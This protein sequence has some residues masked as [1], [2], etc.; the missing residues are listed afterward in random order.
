MPN[1]RNRFNLELPKPTSENGVE[2][3]F[4]CVCLHKE[5]TELL[6][7]NFEIAREQFSIG[8][9]KYFTKVMAVLYLKR[10]CGCYYFK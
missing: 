10:I 3:L 2:Y 9:S 8:E 5:G 7:Q 6:P 4:K 1:L